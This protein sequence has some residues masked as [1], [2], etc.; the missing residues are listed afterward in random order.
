LAEITVKS[1]NNGEI[2][3]VPKIQN[4]LSPNRGLKTGCINGSKRKA[5]KGYV[6]K[7]LESNFS[8]SKGCIVL[9]L[10]R[11]KYS[12]ASANSHAPASISAELGDCGNN[13]YTNDDLIWYFIKLL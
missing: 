13:Q 8:C 7:G 4:I 5:N 9:H 3:V 1:F 12:I 6:N 2:L 11:L 10:L